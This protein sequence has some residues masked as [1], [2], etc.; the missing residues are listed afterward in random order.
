MCLAAEIS[1]LWSVSLKR[2]YMFT[3]GLI[4]SIE[5]LS[6]KILEVLDERV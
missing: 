5:F 4:F 2:C 1:Q 6:I 3:V